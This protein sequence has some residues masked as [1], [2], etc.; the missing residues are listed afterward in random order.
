MA[1]KGLKQESQCG[2]ACAKHLAIG[3]SLFPKDICAAD[4]AKHMR[5]KEKDSNWVFAEDYR[6]LCIW[7]VAEADTN[8]VRNLKAESQTTSSVTLSWEDPEGP[9]NAT[10]TYRI[11]WTGH[12]VTDIT[13]NTYKVEGLQAASQ[14]SF[15]VFAVSN[16]QESTAENVTASTDPNPVRNLKA[17]NQTTS[18]VTLSWED[19]EGPTNATYT[20]GIKWTGH[21]VT[22]ITGNTYKV[23]GLQAA[24]QYSFSVFAVSNGQESTAEPVNASTDP[25]PVRNLKAENQTTS[26]VTL[27]WEDPEGPTN[28]TYTYGIKWTGHE[29]TD[30]TGNTYKVEGLQAASQYSFSVF[31]VSNGQE[32][33]AEPVN[34]STDP[35]PVRNLK[36]ENQTTS[37]V[38]LSWE[39]PE[40]PT[41]ATYTYGIKWTGHEVTDITGNTYKV[42]GLQAASQYSFSVFAVSNGQESTAEPVNASTDPN[43]VRN[44]K[45]ESQTNSSVTLSWEDPEGPTNATYTYGIKWTGHE[46]TDITGN[47]YK[48]EGLQA[49][50]Q[51]SFSVFAV[52]NGQDSTAEPVTA[53]TDPNLVRNLMPETQTTSSITLNWEDPEGPTNANYTYR[54][55]WTGHDVTNITNTTYKVEGLQPASQYSFSVFA[56]SN[57]QESTAEIIT[58]STVPNPVRNLTSESQTTSFVTLNWE[59][60]EG[61]PNANYTYR[62]KWTGHDVTDIKH[63]TYKVEGLQPASQYSFSVF[64]VSNSQESTAK[65]VTAPTVPNEVMNLHNETQT[66]NSITLRWETPSGPPG[67]LYMYQI[68]WASGAQ[69]Q[70]EKTNGTSYRV[71][72]LEPGTLYNL[73]VRAERNNVTSTTQSL[74]ASTAPDPVHISC[75]SASGGYGLALTCLCPRGGFE[76]FLLEVNGQRISLDN[77][78]C[79]REVAVWGLQPARSYVASVQ[80]FWDGMVAPGPSVTCHTSSAGVIAGSIIGVLLAITLVGVLL[81]FLKRRRS[82]KQP[83]ESPLGPKIGLCLLLSRSHKDIRAADFAKHVRGKEKD[84]NWGFAEDYQLLDQDDQP[85]PLQTV[86]LAPE[87][88]SKNR[89]RNVLPYDCARVPLKPLPGEPGSDYIN[90]SFIPGLKKAQEFIATQ[91]PLPHTVGDFWRLVWEQQSHILVMLTNCMESGRVKCEHYWPLDDK[92]CT[93]GHLQVTLEHEDV[94][95]NWTIRTLILRH[96]QEQK[97]LEV[98][99]FHYMTWPDHGVPHCPDPLLE[100][101]NLFREQLER[102]SE[103]GLPVVH[104]SA[105]VGRTGTFI[106]LDVLLRQLECEGC[107]GPF[108]YVKKMRGSR[109]L[110]VQ[111][112]AQY[113]F[114]HQCILRFLEQSSPIEDEGLYE[115]MIYENVGAL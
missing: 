106:A 7:T 65:I 79:E 19:P 12:E 64:A 33:T 61:P 111:T 84:S 108:Q 42:E 36:A 101:R 78:S 95:E 10:Y 99:Q 11:K 50:S 76:T 37:S 83:R 17:E 102:F 25:N 20:Y 46:V 27:S 14:Y 40:G 97:K 57:G 80:T 1:T 48:V 38:T 28:A 59:N 53:S 73:S 91:G 44:L 96:T 5:G 90:A 55:K 105:G 26:S 18:S 41:N 103:G 113:V 81:F 74:R 35:N 67:Q 39:D 56:M 69:S 92:P 86:A 58:A 15:S 68:Q 104:C 98:W 23:E 75:T 2:P 63:T 24:S 32:S 110:M 21:E 9:T 66:N 72:G 4:F 3:F 45:A 71:E 77:S 82:E 34:A 30:I 62:I 8:P 85:Q 31:A 93:H 49:A 107:V 112:E 43:P 89:Y 29:V 109:P 70:R 51:Y 22:D 54:I 100:F 47:T 115:N 6:G 52:S 87:N 60:P 13:G 114:L 16:G 88:Q 94:K